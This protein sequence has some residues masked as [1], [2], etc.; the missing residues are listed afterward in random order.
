MKTKQQIETTIATTK[1][2]LLM[3]VSIHSFQSRGGVRN[4]LCSQVLG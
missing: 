4:P 3:L 1:V 2:L